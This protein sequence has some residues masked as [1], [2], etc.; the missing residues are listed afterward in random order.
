MDILFSKINI[1]NLMIIERST[2]LLEVLQVSAWEDRSD[3]LRR[4]RRLFPSRLVLCLMLLTWTQRTTTAYRLVLHAMYMAW[5]LSKPASTPAPATPR[6]MLAPAP[7]IRLMKPSFFMTCMP[8]SM[9]PLY[10][11]PPPEV[12]IILLLIV[13]MG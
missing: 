11:T 3:G 4:H 2:K 8:Q 13:S 7:F 9:E 5:N 1:Y 12:I 10:L 6:R